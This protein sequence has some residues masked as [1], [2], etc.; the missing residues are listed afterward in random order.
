MHHILRLYDMPGLW[1]LV[2]AVVLFSAYRRIPSSGVVA[3]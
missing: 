2:V 3:D 1:E